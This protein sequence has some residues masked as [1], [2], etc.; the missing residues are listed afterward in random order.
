[1]YR[2]VVTDRM[3]NASTECQYWHY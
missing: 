3:Q 1:M 2:D